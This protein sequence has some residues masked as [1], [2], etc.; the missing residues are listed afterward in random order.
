MPDDEERKIKTGGGAYAE[1]EV[2]TDGGDFVGR[3]KIVQYYQLDV[4][5]LLSTL[6]KAL[7]DGDPAPRQLLET[8][9]GFQHFHTR[10]F[11]W[12]E[13]H[14]LMNEVTFTLDQF[15]REVERNDA[16]GEPIRPRAL[17]RL[18]RPVAQKVD[19]LLEWAGGVQHIAS[20]AFKSKDDGSVVGPGW[21]VELHNARTRL[22][23]A[24]PKADK[25]PQ[26]LY[27]ATFDFSDAA[28]RHMYLAD[29][30]LRD[31]A[32]EL[33]NLS[34]IVLGSMNHGE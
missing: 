17:T 9:Q 7:P 8:L 25:D 26:E 29:K 11:E 21:A 4:E 31:T 18:W 24:L 23:K 27:D 12:K 13:L 19:I 2:S 33:Y 32:Q 15:T 10:L 6:K 16:T 20:P 22:D 28:E 14:N 5:K 1:G 3:D 34:R 30:H